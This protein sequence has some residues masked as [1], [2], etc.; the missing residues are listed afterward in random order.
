MI[1]FGKKRLLAEIE[2]LK[3]ENARLFDLGLRQAKEIKI[4]I[5]NFIREMM[6]LETVIAEK[7]TELSLQKNIYVQQLADLETQ[8]TIHK[9]YVDAN[10]VKIHDLQ[11]ESELLLLQLHQVQEELESVFL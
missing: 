2:S 8:A 4:E 10:D 7:H 3:N 1:F 5:G 6:G 11:S 9:A